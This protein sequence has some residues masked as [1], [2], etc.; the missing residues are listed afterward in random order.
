MKL[1][2]VKQGGKMIAVN[3]QQIEWMETFTPE[4]CR[5]H[6]ASGSHILVDEGLEKVTNRLN[7]AV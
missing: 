2:A 4:A 7:D 3:I 1:V 6:F 5:I